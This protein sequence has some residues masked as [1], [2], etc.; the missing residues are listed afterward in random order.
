MIIWSGWGFLVAIIAVL[1][2]AAAVV[3]AGALGLEGDAENVLLFSSF[4]PAGIAIWYLGR[5]LNRGAVRELI[6]PQTGQTVLLRNSHT[7]FFIPVEWWGP[8]IAV[9]GLL[10]ALVL[11]LVPGD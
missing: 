1:A 8:I 5:R 11:L 6:D 3:V 4:I 7:F 2:A 9:G 10:A